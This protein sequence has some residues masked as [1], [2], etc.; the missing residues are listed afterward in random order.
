MISLST[1]SDSFH[2][3]TIET[4]QSTC[5]AHQGHGDHMALQRLGG[6]RGLLGFL[7]HDAHGGLD[8]DLGKTYPP[9]L[10]SSG[11]T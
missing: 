7:G 10:I 5:I 9:A 3:Y 1:V 2:P 8:A 11:G 4:Q 6:K